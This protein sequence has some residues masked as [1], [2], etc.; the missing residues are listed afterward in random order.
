MTLRG[1]AYSS[2]SEVK[3]FARY[4]LDGESGFNSTTRPTASEVDEIINGVSGAVNVALR[5]EGLSDSSL[6]SNSTASGF[7]S[8]WVR[9]KTVELV[10]L[11]Q[12]GPSLESE[13]GNRS[14][15]FRGLFEEARQFVE[16]HSLAFKRMGV[17]VT[18]R[19]S[20]G[21]YFTGFKPHADRSDPD[22]STLRQPFFERGLFGNL[23]STS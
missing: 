2:T 6:R 4:L 17:T 12:L 13:G 10:E 8:D 9:A 7:V 22:D 21:L 19:A 3:V 16:S 11:T 14:A 1:D 15:A 23:N 20:Q 18:D 5:G